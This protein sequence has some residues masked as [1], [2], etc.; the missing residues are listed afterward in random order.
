M[1]VFPSHANFLLLELLRADPKAVVESLYTAGV[2]VRDVTAYPRL[3]RCLRV[4]V[5]SEPENE[6]LLAGLR[7]A[8][9]EGS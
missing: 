8:L 7:Q 2:L 3:S 6:R 9:Q 1:R 4:S 5:G